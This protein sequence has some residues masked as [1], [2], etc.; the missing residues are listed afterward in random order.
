MKLSNLE[1]S[2]E[3]IIE[4]INDHAVLEDLY[5]SNKKSFS[6]IIYS[7][8]NDDSELIIKYWYTRLFYR[9]STGKINVKKCIFTIILIIFAWVPIRLGFIDS[10]YYITRSVP[11]IFSIMLS[12]FFL[13]GSL[14]IKNILFC[15]IPCLILYIYYIF[16]PDNFSSQSLNNTLYFIFVLLW[17]SVLLSHINYNFRKLEYNS[18]LEKCGEVIVWSTIFMIGF[19]IINFLLMSLF[20]AIGIQAW[21]FFSD[22]M[23]TLGFVASPFV[24][25]LIIENYKTKLSVIIAKIFLPIIL[26]SLVAFGIT[27]IFSETKPYEDRNVFIMYN[28]MNTL[29]LCILVFTGI[30][31][32][33]NKIL[34][35][36]SKVLPVVTIILNIITLSAVIYRISEYG[37]TPNK[38]TLLGTNIV[39]LGHLIYIVYLNYK[40]NINK[41]VLYLPVYFIWALIVVFVFSFLFNFS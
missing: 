6:E 25:L 34:N 40:N 30:D 16:L 33:K 24:S 7:I 22:Y 20:G 19:S 41:N 35:I 9:P 4:N 21:R 11:I 29:V 8:H 14:K 17:F 15:I 18:F 10:N 2:K 39:M 26:V 36:C 12:L 1:V 13:Y 27:S 28:I 31:G 32:I 23:F 38:I 37:I 3:T 5:Q